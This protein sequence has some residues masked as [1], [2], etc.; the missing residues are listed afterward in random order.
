[1]NI[2]NKTVIISGASR[3][4]GRATALLL[5]HQGAN[6][7]ATARNAK[8]LA[9]L[10]EEHPG[11]VAVPG[12]VANEADMANVVQ[13]ALDRFGTID[14]VINNAGYGIFKNVEEI[15]A[16][17]WD[18]L[19]ATNVKGTF[20]LTKAA[21]PTLKAQGSGHVVVVASDVAKRTF[22]GGSL[23]TASKYAQEAFMGA[24]RKEVRPMGIKVSGVY[25]GLVDSHFHDKGHGHET[26]AHYLKEQ[27]VAESMLFIVS[28]PAHVVIDEFMVHPL[29]Q[30]Y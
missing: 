17:E 12:D 4:I 19:M 15:T 2:Q 18:D 28:R 1:M 16:T 22:A 6:V 24:L 29:E 9:A 27:D 14:I 30:E 5:A 11:I 10:E 26:S 8:D 7:I 25:T 13:V 20:L 21:L 23:Y 3:G